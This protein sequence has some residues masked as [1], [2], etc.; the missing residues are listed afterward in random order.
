MENLKEALRRYKTQPLPNEINMDMR[1][2]VA[3][4]L[5]K[6]HRDSVSGQNVFCDLATVMLGILA[7]PHSNAEAERIF[8][9]VRRTH[10]DTRSSMKTDMLFSLLTLKVGRFPSLDKE[11][12]RRCKRATSDFVKA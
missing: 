4:H 2:D 11:L 1:A 6:E 9:M 3:W 7:I 10:T 5:L 8:S 12:L